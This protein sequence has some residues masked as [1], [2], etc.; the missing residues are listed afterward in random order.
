MRQITRQNIIG[1]NFSLIL[2]QNQTPRNPVQ[3]R[4]QT[5]LAISLEARS[6]LCRRA[7][8]N[9]CAKQPDHR[10]HYSY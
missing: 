6:G 10:L 3:G 1:L 8:E 5:N 4:S 7:G 9:E 2:M